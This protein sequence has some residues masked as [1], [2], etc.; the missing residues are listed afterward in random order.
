MAMYHVPWQ[1]KINSAVEGLCGGTQFA[2]VFL[3]TCALSAKG[4][5]K[6]ICQTEFSSHADC[7]KKWFRFL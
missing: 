6:A 7:R 2:T 4:S 5:N 1:T 3:K